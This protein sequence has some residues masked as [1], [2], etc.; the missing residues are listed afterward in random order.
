MAKVDI[1]SAFRLLPI[2]PEDFCQLG[3]QFEGSYYIERDLSMGCVVACTHFE[4]FS[5]FLDWAIRSR[6]G[7]PYVLH[8][9]YD[10]LFIGPS[11]SGTSKRLLS[12]FVAICESL[13]IPLA[14]G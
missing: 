13:G 4:D 6:S 5:T 12:K 14:P 9:L 7:C 3:F 1:E 8:Y 10:F 2:H 11:E